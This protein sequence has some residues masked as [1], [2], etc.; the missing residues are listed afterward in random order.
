MINY[1]KIIEIILCRCYA[2]ESN[3][4][5]AH[6]NMRIASIIFLKSIAQNATNIS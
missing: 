4:S 2:G 6:T 1:Y 5:T 3:I